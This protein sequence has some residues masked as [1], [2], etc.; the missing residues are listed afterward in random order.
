MNT[1]SLKNATELKEKYFTFWK[2]L[3][4]CNIKKEENGFDIQPLIDY[5]SKKEDI[6]IY[7]FYEELQE[8]LELLETDELMD[9]YEEKYDNY[10]S[11][12]GFLY[13]R[14][15]VLLKGVDYVWNLLNGKIKE[16]WEDECEFLL[17]V[18]SYAWELKYGDKIEEIGE[19][20]DY[21]HCINTMKREKEI[22]SALTSKNAISEQTALSFEE[23]GIEKP[24]RYPFFNDELIKRGILAKTK[25]GKYYLKK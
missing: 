3:E 11:I 5:L 6:E 22:I 19:F 24:T 10:F 12:D 1:N 17:Y 9:S 23:A 21:M 4:D 18:C 2:F 15:A 7:N 16:K 25:N 14:C 13:A 8:L 20:Y